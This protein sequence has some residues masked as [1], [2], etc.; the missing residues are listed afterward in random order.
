[1]VWMT[2]HNLGQ[3]RSYLT[4]RRQRCFVNGQFSGTSSTSRGVPHEGS[5]IGPLLFL[6]YINDLP[7]CLNEGFTR[8]FADD[9]NLNFSS[10]NLSLKF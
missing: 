7:N 10:D 5:I 6:V 3:C 4:D 9:T 8:M 1:M 2:W